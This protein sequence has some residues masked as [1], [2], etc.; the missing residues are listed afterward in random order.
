MIPIRIM[1]L[2]Q[3]ITS[4]E[5]NVFGWLKIKY[6]INKYTPKAMRAM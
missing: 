5:L 4:A 1:K 3:K 6:F 2:A